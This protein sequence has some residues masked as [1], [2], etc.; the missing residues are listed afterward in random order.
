MS[1]KSTPP[2]LT[3]P[4]TT[5]EQVSRAILDAMV[6]G[7]GYLRIGNGGTW[8]RVDPRRIK[9]VADGDET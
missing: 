2:D 4:D 7:T 3:P 5:E 8:E 1:S 9:I 6:Y